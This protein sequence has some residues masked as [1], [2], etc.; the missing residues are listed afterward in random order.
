MLFYNFPA[1]KET[2]IFVGI[3]W[4]VAIATDEYN[5]RSFKSLIFRGHQG[6]VRSRIFHAQRSLW[7]HL[8]SCCWLRVRSLYNSSSGMDCERTEFVS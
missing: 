1:K 5:D 3:M 6:V 8:E 4:M 7:V 2:E